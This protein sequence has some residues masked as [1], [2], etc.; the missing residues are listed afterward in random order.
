[1]KRM[2]GF[3]LQSSSSSL[4]L[5]LL[6]L[7]LL[8]SF[9]S[10]SSCS[11]LVYRP[12]FYHADASLESKRLLAQ[13]QLAW[14]KEEALLRPALT[15]TVFLL[16]VLPSL[17]CVPLVCFF[18]VFL[19]FLFLL[20]F[21]SVCLCV[22]CSLSHVSPSYPVS[23]IGCGP[24][25]VSE[26]L[27]RSFVQLNVICL[28]ADSRF[29]AE[30]R[31]RL[32]AEMG[33]R[34]VVVRGD[35]SREETWSR[36]GQL[37]RG[38]GGKFDAVLARLVMQHMPG[39]QVE[40]LKRAKQFLRQEGAVMLLD[41]DESLPDIVQPEFPLSDA[42]LNR[43]NAHREKNNIIPDVKV[44]RKLR[45]ML[46]E[47]G[48]EKATC[49]A[50]QSSSDDCGWDVLRTLLSPIQLKK[51]K[52]E[53]KDESFLILFFPRYSAVANSSELEAAEQELDRLVPPVWTKG[54][55]DESRP[56]MVSTLMVCQAFVPRS[57]V[58]MVETHDLTPSE[59]Q[60]LAA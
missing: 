55:T 40:L 2:K 4:F 46:E 43:M 28:E 36:V 16:E 11:S 24:G 10:L 15:R 49:D 45:G 35:A 56:L 50:A 30:A 23:K 6:L 26:R 31:A 18:V 32:G 12:E 39:K 33:A 48:F 9:C 25:H 21:C 22:C 17:F 44:G 52:R 14:A 20:L 37:L 5:F 47:V 29:V 54:R 53:R 1:M 41:V 8:S 38:K 60:L 57:S 7:L 13:V 42:L 19:L 3:C 59:E 27:L 51:K 34:F 58:A